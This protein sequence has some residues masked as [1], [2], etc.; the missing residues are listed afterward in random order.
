MGNY[1]L[2]NRVHNPLGIFAMFISF[3]YGSMIISF[4]IGINNLHGNVERWTIIFFL[5]GFPLVILGL[6][7]WLL[8]KHTWK[9]YSPEDFPD[10]AFLRFMSKKEITQDKNENFKELSGLVSHSENAA[11]D[12]PNDSF[13]YKYDKYCRIAIEKLSTYL[14]VRLS[15]NIRS[16]FNKKIIF[17]AVGQNQYGNYYIEFKYVPQQP[18]LYWYN[19]QSILLKRYSDYL[20]KNSKYYQL[21]FVIVIEK[22]VDVKPIKEYFTRNNPNIKVETYTSEELEKS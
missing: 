15:M 5:V 9:L 6:F 7:L 13:I 22:A 10:G 4:S 16:R 2:Q 12:N 1:K 11:T 21:I 20:D 18:D 8:T 17:D 19:R 3:V 14:G